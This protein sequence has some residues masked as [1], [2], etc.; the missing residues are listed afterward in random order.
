[1]KKLTLLICTAY[2][3]NA[4]AQSNIGIN[5]ASPDASSILDI[6]H[7]A[8]GLLIPRLQLVASNNPAP[9][10]APA[11]SLLV[12]NLLPSGV[13]PNDVK[14]GYYYWDGA[15]W[16]GIG[17]APPATTNTLSSSVNTI[18]STVDG[19]VAT[20]PA[21]NT[22]SNTL[23]GTN[24][25]TT[26]NGIAGTAINL[27]TIVPA[28][29]N[30]MSSTGNTI[31][32]T[33]NGV[34]ATA[35]AVNT[36]SNALTGT[37]LTTTVNGV[38]G[39]TL[40]LSTIIPPSNNWSLLG[41]AGTVAA[42]NFVGT[43][44]AVDLVTRTNNTE[45]MRVTSAGNVGIGTTT[46]NAK[47]LLDMVS[48][49][50]GLLMPRVTTVQRLA[51]NNNTADATIAGLQ[52]YDLTTSTF[53]YH[54]GTYWVQASNNPDPS[55]GA[56]SIFPYTSIP[57]DYLE[58][59]GSAVS[60][61]TYAALFAKIGTTYGAGDG[62]TTFNLPDLRGEFVRGFDNG[63][64]ADVARVMGSAQGDAIRNI[65]GQ[66]RAATLGGLN[67][68]T[69]AIG[70]VSGFNPLHAGGGGY[71]NGGATYNLD[72]SLQVPTAAENR[73][74]NVAMVYAIKAIPTTVTYGSNTTDAQTLSITGN[75]LSI[76]NGNSV[77]LPTAPAAGS[78]V[79]V[80]T[81]PTSGT[82][83]TNTNTYPIYVTFTANFNG[84][85][86]GSW[87]YVYL[88]LNGQLIKQNSSHGAFLY[89]YAD[90]VIIPP[91]M[92]YYFTTSASAGT[93]TVTNLLE[94]K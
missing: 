93:T 76:S 52:V 43:T 92:S 81:I 70:L 73:P 84:A 62:S 24:L 39:A 2:T 45:K 54:D 16:V 47:A 87:S 26:V 42:T 28:T 7:N 30:T 56:I 90:W 41:N 35:P 86:S 3:L 78:W 36:V 58:C 49:S 67:F 55:L 31:T 69:G 44:D 23:T 5:T 60:R 10:V 34:I 59:N 38:V 82:P 11:L 29:T 9:I 46:P 77:V 71:A 85:S 51:I 15:K 75:T 91:G 22:V 1:M 27:S 13:F 89:G 20:A 18:T 48:T 8:R 53:W 68:N 61:S 12:F 6:T 32:N 21:V 65:T 88:Y 74:R 83:R 4:T 79:T 33:T 19:L 64:G 25:T 63:R 50:K 94:Y 57:T 80:G 66:F 40:D 17:G 37:N 72:A 14:T